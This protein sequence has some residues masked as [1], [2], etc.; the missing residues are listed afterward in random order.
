MSEALITKHWRPHEKQLEFLRLPHTIFEG[1]YGG[2]AGGG[3]SEVLL[4][5]PIY[6]EWYKHPKFKGI[7]FRR[8]FPQL[9]ESLIPRSRD[10]YKATGAVYNDQKHVW[11]WPSGASIR[12]GY[13]DQ[14]KDALD[15]DTAEYNYLAFDELT[16]FTEFMYIYLTSRVRSSIPALPAIVRSA[17]NPGN[18]GHAW[19]RDRFV[20]P[21][22]DGRR[23]LIDKRTGNKRIFIPAKLTD[24]PSLTENDP[25]YINRL[26]MLPEAERRAKI[27]GDWWIFSGQVFSEFRSLKLGSEPSNALHVIPYFE[28]PDWWTKGL[29]IDWGYSHKAYALWGAVSPD[30]RFIIAREHSVVKTSV[31]T[32]GAQVA[33]ITHSLGSD[34]AFSTLDPSTWGEGKGLDNTIATQLMESTEIAFDKADNDRIGGKLLVHEG[35]RFLPRPPKYIPP[36]GYDTETASRILR[37]YGTKAYNDYQNMFMPDKPETNI[38]VIQIMDSCPELIECIPLCVYDEKHVEDVEK[39]DGDDPY[40]TLRYWL[41][42]ANRYLDE[43]KDKAI[44]QSNLSIILSK[45]KETGDYNYLHRQMEKYESSEEDY[46]VVRRGRSHRIT[47][48][49]R[50]RS[51]I[52]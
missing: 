42:R 5:E 52:H 43:M 30:L 31:K 32:F 45:F 46:G 3:K 51:T 26:Q 35:L 1:M 13:L 49:S 15:H 38:P 10:F 25:N 2:A 50:E 8:T 16:A 29:A 11:N 14:D 48:I 39:F 36:S 41:K 27:D 24:N 7:I 12:F 9:E 4:M 47:R 34:M 21:A 28:I 23:I 19:V 20:K 33:A 40:D 17:T 18:V 37:M 44:R 22:P 6:H